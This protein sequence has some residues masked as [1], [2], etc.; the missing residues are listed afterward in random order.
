MAPHPSLPE[1]LVVVGRSCRHP[2]PGRH[3]SVGVVLPARSHRLQRGCRPTEAH[4]WP[5]DE[6]PEFCRAYVECG[7]NALKLATRVS[8][9]APSRA[10]LS[11]TSLLL[12][13]G[14]VFLA[15]WI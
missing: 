7:P 15:R 10:A 12:H 13:A 14:F 5:G 1:T 2:N 3:L 9:P 4:G 6:K 11:A 8:A